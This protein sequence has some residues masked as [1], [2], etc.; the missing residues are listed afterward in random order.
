M[1]K[2]K[3]GELEN[4]VDE[5]CRSRVTGGR[6]ESGLIPVLR[7]IQSEVGY[8]PER[9]LRRVS[10][11]LGV[12]PSRVYGVATFYH[13]FRLQP[14]G[15]HTITQCMGTACHVSGA[16][17]IHDFLLRHLGIAHPQD[18]SLDGGFTVRQVRCIGACSLA[19]IVKIDDKIYSRMDAR[20][21]KKLLDKYRKEVEC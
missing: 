11:N 4:L 9:A 20:K 21:L 15:K 14:E 13:I 1:A 10:S 2:L 16:K 5:I 7:D 12:S 3:K 17:E 18:T 6:H 8:L 19:P